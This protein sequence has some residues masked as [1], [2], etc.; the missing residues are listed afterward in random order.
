VFFESRDKALEAKA[1]LQKVQL[2]PGKS[3]YVELYDHT[4]E[5]FRFKCYL[6]EFEN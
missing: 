2:T 6:D 3:R 5:H 1:E 4:D